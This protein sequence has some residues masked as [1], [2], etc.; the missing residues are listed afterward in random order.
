MNHF[1]CQVQKPSSYPLKL[2]VRRCHHWQSLIGGGRATGMQISFVLESCW[3][4]RRP[5]WTG[6]H[7]LFLSLIVRYVSKIREPNHPAALQQ[8]LLLLHK[9]KRKCFAVISESE[10]CP[11]RVGR[12]LISSGKV[13]EL[14]LDEGRMKRNVTAEESSDT[15]RRALLK[16]GRQL[17]HHQTIN[18]QRIDRSRPQSCPAF[19]VQMML[20]QHSSGPLWGS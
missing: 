9:R 2:F 1:N 15:D 10:Q 16:S 11:H 6:A 19:R 14:K 12:S 3:A 4:A 17:W 13:K 7:L 20:R 18:N 8:Q 5:K